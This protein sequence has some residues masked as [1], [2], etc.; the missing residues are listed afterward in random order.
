MWS[1]LSLGEVRSLG[2]K[3]HFYIIPL[4]MVKIT[5]NSSTRDTGAIPIRY[6]L[7]VFPAFS[8]LVGNDTQFT[9]L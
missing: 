7:V 1:V 6:R 3:E 8:L 5:K 4:V 2:G 9:G